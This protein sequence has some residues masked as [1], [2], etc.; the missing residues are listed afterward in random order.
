[1]PGRGQ[2]YI[3]ALEGKGRWEVVVSAGVDPLTGKR[4]RVSRVVHGRK[5]DA[6]RALHALHAEVDRT[7]T[8]LGSDSSLGALI[9][10]YLRVTQLSPT[11]R[12]DY[13]RARRQMLPSIVEDVALWKL[14]AND[15]DSL[16]AS[17]R[18]GHS[19]DR[20]IR[21]HTLISAALT[22]AV[23][24]GWLSRNVAGDATPPAAPR[25]RVR[26]PQQDAVALLLDRADPV[27]AVFLRLAFV[28]GARRGELCGLQWG[29]Y[30]SGGGP[31][32]KDGLQPTREA[33]PPGATGYDAPASRL[34]FKRAV[35]YTPSS[36]I[37][38]KS[39]KSDRERVVTL[40]PETAGILE[41][42][43]TEEAMHIR[44]TPTSFIFARD[45]YGKQ[46]WRPDFASWKF[47]RLRAELG[48]TGVRLHDL[49]HASASYALR[50]GIEMAVVS[51]RLGHSRQST[52]ADIYSHVI[53]GRDAEA[54]S[55]L[56]GMLVHDTP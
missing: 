24:W 38:I 16:Y 45:P 26:P 33:S 21:L 36:G 9:T 27:F 49:R 32:R 39:T 35:V 22:R 40:D 3:R 46:P 25:R 1:V 42:H 5:D 23:K 6:V 51:K 15:L 11:M 47:G 55:A 8:R 50:A 29:D 17:L 7:H 14:R 54:A 41:G 53:E 2:G 20:I 34:W 31:T 10:E 4:R 44:L 13:Q 56:A 43:R 30:E 18:A 12:D 52:T 48:L 37:V 28:T 19:P